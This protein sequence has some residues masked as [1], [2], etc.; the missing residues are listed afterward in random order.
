MTW[1]FRGV[2]SKDAFWAYVRVMDG[3]AFDMESVNDEVIGLGLGD[4][5]VRAYASGE[6][7]AT[8]MLR[9]FLHVQKFM[10]PETPRIAHSAT[11]DLGAL[12]VTH[13]PEFYPIYDTMVACH[14]LQ[15]ELQ[16]NALNLQ[17]LAMAVCDLQIDSFDTITKRYKAKDLSGVPEIEIAK[18]NLSQIHATTKLWRATQEKFSTLPTLKKV[19]ELEMRVLPILAK[20][21]DAGI[22]VDRSRLLALGR[23]FAVEGDALQDAIRELTN[24]Q[25]QNV[26]SPLQVSNYIF[27]IDTSAGQLAT[28]IRYLT[29]KGA[30]QTSERVLKKLL[31]KD[32]EG[33]SWLR[34]LLRARQIKKLVNTYCIGIATRLD[35]NQRSHTQLSQVSTGTGRLASKEPNHQNIPKR[36]I[37]GLEIRRCMIAPPGHLL[38]A[39]DMDQI[40]LRIIAEE[41]GEVKM[42]EAFLSGK[43]IHL[44]TAIDIFNG[45]ADRF[46]A[47]VFNYTIAYLAGPQQVADQLR[48][49]KKRAEYLQ[50]TYFRKYRRL[51]EWL[52]EWDAICKEQG[53]VETW[54]GRRRNLTAFYEDPRYNHPS[55]GFHLPPVGRS[56]SYLVTDGM[57]K[58]V[59]TRIQGTAAEVLKQLMVKVDQRLTRDKMQTRCLMAIHDELL[60]ESPFEEVES[61]K[62]LL[63]EEMTTLY[64]AMPLP[65]TVKVGENWADVH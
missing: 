51:T 31:E 15:D 50:E 40:E 19:Y 42:Q 39:C 56:P 48:V 61:T 58:A 49:S 53:Y 17:Y 46:K 20:M 52:E 43:D 65:C 9:R 26:N 32:P 28:R 2:R 38:I 24:G 13:F 18:Y 33:F 37:E 59:N 25:I 6:Y 64:K 45:P 8:E 10:L 4:D 57:R 12:G 5:E 30:P 29:K 11:S 1:Y 16:L 22:M 63:R 7:A 35:E 34:I 21:E 55:G 27:G 60:L 41:A 54:Y 3:V 23:R 14:I 62:L 44:Q 36:R 47:K